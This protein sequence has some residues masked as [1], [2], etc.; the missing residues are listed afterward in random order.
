MADEQT[1]SDDALLDS[2]VTLPP[3]VVHR[4]F[5]EETVVLNLR[6]GMYH[7]LNKSAGELLTAMEE[8]LNPRAAAARV[9]ESYGLPPADVETDVVSLCR[10]LLKRE[11]IEVDLGA[12][13]PA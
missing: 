6:T 10:G 11:L 9:A 2:A 5:V 7:G 1:A 4:S 12:E 13:P 3:H 8:G